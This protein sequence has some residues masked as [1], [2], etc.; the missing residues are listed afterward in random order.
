MYARVR[1]IKPV[2]PNGLRESGYEKGVQGHR[3]NRLASNHGQ[4]QF[5]FN[6][7]GEII[8]TIYHS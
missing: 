8:K 5:I 4:R 1:K 6:G 2:K 3:N 7:R